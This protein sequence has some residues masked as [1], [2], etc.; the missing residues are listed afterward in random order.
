MVEQAQASILAHLQLI[1][2][3]RQVST[4][5]WCKHP[6]TQG[7]STSMRQD[8]LKAMVTLGAT[9]GLTGCGESD[10][11]KQKLTMTIATP[12]GTVSASSVN[13][14]R[15]SFSEDALWATTGYA[16][17]ASHKGEAIVMEVQPG[18]YLFALLDERIELLALRVFV[19]D[20]AASSPSEADRRLI[21]GAQGAKPVSSRHYPLLVMFTDINDPKSVREVKPEKLSDVF[22]VGFFLQAITLEITDEDVTEGEIEKVLSWIAKYFDQHFD[23][24]RIQTTKATNRL[25]NSLTAGKFTTWRK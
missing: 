2:T 19:G 20:S 25:A 13:E 9:L 10:T 6:L 4:K 21:Q 7:D 5:S 16:Y 1:S 17:D 15:L 3:L 8:F 23:G 18:I 12:N 24:N 14:I 11:W 22:G